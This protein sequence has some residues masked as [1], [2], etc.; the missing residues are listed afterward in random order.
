MEVLA[1]PNSLDTTFTGTPISKGLATIATCDTLSLRFVCPYNHSV[2]GRKSLL[3]FS[4]FLTVLIVIVL[5]LQLLCYV[6][7]SLTL[8][9][10][11]K[12]RGFDRMRKAYIDTI[13]PHKLTVI[14]GV[15]GKSTL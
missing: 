15:Q 5:L 2:S 3:T 7:M 1:C 8:T 10:I 6:R 12:Q 9:K 13:T 4:T 11:V 14:Q